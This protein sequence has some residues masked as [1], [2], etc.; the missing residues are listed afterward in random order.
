M[1]SFDTE[2]EHSWWM[3]WITGMIVL[4]GGYF[5]TLLLILWLRLT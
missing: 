3:H 2:T 1:I 4:A 5:A